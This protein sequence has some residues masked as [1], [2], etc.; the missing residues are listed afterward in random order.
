MPLTSRSSRRVETVCVLSRWGTVPESRLI[1]VGCLTCKKKRLKCDE[2]KPTC[3]QCHKRSVT[4]EGYKKIFQWKAFEETTF[5]SK[6][7]SQRPKKGQYDISVTRDKRLKS[8]D[9]YL[10]FPGGNA[11]SSECRSS[12][13]AVDEDG[14]DASVSPVCI[15]SDADDVYRDDDL[16]GP[17]SI[18]NIPELHLDTNVSG[19]QT[20]RG[21]LR[22]LQPNSVTSSLDSLFNE[23]GTSGWSSARSTPDDNTPVWP[24]AGLECP[25]LTDSGDPSLLSDP[26][27]G[28]QPFFMDDTGDVEEVIREPV[29]PDEATWMSYIGPTSM[30]PPSGSPSFNFTPLYVQPGLMDTE[31]HRADMLFYRYDCHTC[32]ILSVKDG[33]NENPW[34]TTIFP[35]INDC[36]A[37]YHAV[38]AMTAFHISKEDPSFRVLGADHVRMASWFLRNKIEY[39][40][41]EMA[42][43]T[44]ISL[45]FAESWDQHISTG[46]M[47]LKAA[48]YL[49]RR[50]AG[51]QDTTSMS[52]LQV[53][54][55][56]F[57]LNTWVYMDV[58]S[59]LTS[60]DDDD[61]S[62][63]FDH[64]L[65]PSIATGQRCAE[66]D[67]LM[68]CASSLFPWIGRAAN[69]CHEV[70]ICP[71]NTPNIVHRARKIKEAIERWCPGAVADYEPPEDLESE[72]HDAIQTAEAYRYATLLYLHQMVPEIPSLTSAQLA[73]KAL[74]HLSTVSPTSR[75]V[76]VHIFPLLAAGCEALGDDRTVVS[77]RWQAMSDRMWIGNVDKCHEVTREVW[78]RRDDEAAFQAMLETTP[79]R[80]RPPLSQDCAFDPNFNVMDLGGYEDMLLSDDLFI[81]PHPPARTKR[82]SSSYCSPP[83]TVPSTPIVTTKRVHHAKK[84][85]P[86][87]EDLDPELTVRGQMHWIGVM[88]EW[89]WE[90]KSMIPILAC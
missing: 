43:A 19:R 61:L 84:E 69:L 39:M 62:T 32:G 38:A 65:T 42:L 28:T 55:R 41:I 5:N 51:Q 56:K 72:T 49:I 82:S 74:V 46:G 25:S 45:A 14:P 8:T 71:N 47:H 16:R 40:N 81:G 64:A 83:P 87:W 36:E 7:T 13:S 24:D 29:S 67:P 52:S 54:Q 27:D 15:E 34:R 66:I 1:C 2:T 80:F 48:R 50:A 70:L 73:K 18:D 75:L 31:E 6:L 30:P 63:D 10:P 90:G 88:R 68:G 22:L 77:E 33:L 57:L 78:K 76:I 86:V 89:K 37:L 4:C 44:I 26:T 58:I 23:V 17:S 60:F 85:K 53:A 21:G 79:P 35:M 3:L 12:N 59:R 20:P 9:L 11:R